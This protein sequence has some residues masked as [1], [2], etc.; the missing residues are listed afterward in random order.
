MRSFFEWKKEKDIISEHQSQ[1]DQIVEQ[2]LHL[3]KLDEAVETSRYSVE[4]NYRTTSEEA[5]E[6]FAK[7]CLGY[8]SAA[9]KKHGFH[10]KHVFTEKPLRLLVAARNWDDGEW[11][12][13]V[14]WYASQ[15]CFVLSKGFYNKDRKTVRI[16]DSKQCDGKSA[17]EIHKELFN[18]MT[19][20]KQ[21]PDD[22][23]EKLKPALMKRGPKR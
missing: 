1:I 8:I 9:I 4:V 21:L 3:F 2:C 7:I 12:G 18:T 17:A 10:T 16:K 20:L 6:G 15:N 19:H 13:V 23:K 22:H 14:S 5:L 11:V